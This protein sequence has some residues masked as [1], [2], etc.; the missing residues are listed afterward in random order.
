[1]VGFVA[2]AGVLAAF[3]KDPDISWLS[4]LSVYGMLLVWSLSLVAGLVGTW[5]L[6]ALVLFTF[7]KYLSLIQ[8]LTSWR[9]ADR[10]ALRM[11]NDTHLSHALPGSP[12]HWLHKKAVAAV[13]SAMKTQRQSETHA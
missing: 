11:A 6:G 7:W 4:A 5:Y 2:A 1:L 13:S 10:M 3:K 8:W 12:Y 9:L